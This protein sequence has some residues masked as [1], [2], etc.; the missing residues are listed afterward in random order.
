[1]NLNYFDFKTK[2][3][4]FYC[5]YKNDPSLSDSDPGKTSICYLGVGKNNFDDYLEKLRKTDDTLVPEYRKNS[6]ISS[7]VNDFLSGKRKSIDIRTFFLTGTV[8]EQTVWNKAKEIDYGNKT[9]YKQLSEKV[10]SQAG[11]PKSYRAVGNALGK[12]PLILIVPCH[13]IIKSNGDIG[14]FS[15]GIPLKKKLLDLEAKK[16]VNP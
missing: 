8:F 7:A 13:R 6:M 11:K 2:D 3:G 14:N 15:S 16:D 12:N 5:I 10:C 4:D 1:M 9:S